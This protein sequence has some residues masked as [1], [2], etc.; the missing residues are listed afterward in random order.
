M[1]RAIVAVIAGVVV[2]FGM[3]LLVE[4]IGHF[5]VPTASAPSYKDAEQMREYLRTLPVGAYA[6]VLLAYLV[7]S[8]VGGRVAARVTRSPRS[9][10]VWVVGA[11]VLAATIAN[12]VM[13]VHPVWFTSAAVLA[14]FAGTWLATVTTRRL[15]I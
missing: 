8:Y 2:A 9:V 1:A 6:F 11:L 5:V 14:V 15:N 12:L 3:I 4:T 7:G 13:I 10:S